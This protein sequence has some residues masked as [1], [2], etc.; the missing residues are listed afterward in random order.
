VTRGGGGPLLVI[1]YKYA[2]PRAEAAERY[3]LQLAAYALAVSRAHGGAPVEARLQ[4]LRGDL[5]S[6]DVT[7]TAEELSA[8]ARD[9]PALAWGVATGAGDRPPA[10]LGR[11]Q[12]RCRGEGCGFVE[13]CFAAPFDPA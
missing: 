4:F 3:R 9:A 13:R 8:L 10:A 1:D 11:D 2:L 6:L 7:P 12:A 5:A